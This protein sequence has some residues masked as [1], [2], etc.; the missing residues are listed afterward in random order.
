MNDAPKKRPWLQFH[1][2]TAIVLMFV[3]SGLLALNVRTL[4]ERKNSF[5]AWL[6]PEYQ[7]NPFMWEYGWPLK[8]YMWRP[9]GSLDGDGCVQCFFSQAAIAD[10]A[11]ALGVLATLAVVSERLLR[12]RERRP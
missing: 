12:R 7:A 10:V 4:W 6:P 9:F 2:S 11:V 1:L 3:A 5:V 8:A